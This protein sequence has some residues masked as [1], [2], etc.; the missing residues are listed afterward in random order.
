MTNII[1]TLSE[2]NK[3][4]SMIFL[5]MFCILLS[6]VFIFLS[7]QWGSMPDWLALASAVYMGMSITT[8]P[9]FTIYILT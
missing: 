8:L 4:V 9:I 6:M 7:F 3:N 1:K 2:D 5:H